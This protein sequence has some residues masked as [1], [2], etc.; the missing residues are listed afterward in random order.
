MNRL[1][2]ITLAVLL[3]APLAASHAADKLKLANKPNIL[4][5]RTDDRSP[6]M[7]GCF[8]GKVLTAASLAAPLK[9]RIVVLT[10]VSTWET[11]DS[12]SLV[13]LLA[14]ADL[15]EI[16]GLVYTTGWSLET[17][18]DDFLDLLHAAINKP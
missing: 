10:D 11:D 14:H 4:F 9:P 15:F 3:L 5:I 1:T 12:E 6:D 18:R 16:E 13:R 8:G 2:T 7:L 17:T